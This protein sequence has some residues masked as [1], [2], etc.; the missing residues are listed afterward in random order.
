MSDL[1]LVVRDDLAKTIL[2]TPAAEAVKETVLAQAALIG[3]VRNAKENEEAVQAQ[4]ALRRLAIL[5]E[6]ARKSLKE[7][8]LEFGRTIDATTWEWTKDIGEEQVRLA[9]L[10][11]DFQALENRRVMSAQQAKN[12]NLTLIERE[13]AEELSLAET[14]EEVDAINERYARKAEL[15]AEPPPPAR[16]PG[17]VV[18]SD[19][20]ITVTDVWLLAKS[21]PTCVTITPRLSE[22][23]GLLNAGVKVAGVK[24]ERITKAQVRATTQKAIDV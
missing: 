21:H 6:K 15:L 3:A 11:S 4:L 14:I 2:F 7:P 23:K 16:A 17:Q 1:T 8:I 12:Q 9:T 13:K 10:I 20:D 19:W 22:I 24:A 5:V 18:S